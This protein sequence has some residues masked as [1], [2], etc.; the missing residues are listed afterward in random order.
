MNN[1]SLGIIATVLFAIPVTAHADLITNGDFATDANGW[2]FNRTS[3]SDWGWRSTGNPGGSFWVNH[4]GGDVSATDPDPM[5]TQLMSTVSGQQYT[6]TFD[7]ARGVYG[8]GT[9]LAVDL[10]G[11]QQATYQIFNDA[12]WRTIS[13]VFTA[14]GSSTLLGFRT[15][16]NG[17]DWDAYI[18]NVSVQPY[19]TNIVPEPGTLSLLGLGLACLGLA[20]R[21][22][23]A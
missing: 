8:G 14:T 9:G 21:R 19:Q 13:F 11:V 15:E 18:D 6:L 10:D 23:F 22:K 3:G 12:V 17:S 5:L 1:K 4:N 2:T 20:R 16:I 7:Y